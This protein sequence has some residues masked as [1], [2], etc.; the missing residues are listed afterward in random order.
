MIIKINEFIQNIINNITDKI[1]IYDVEY[2]YV[3]K[4]DHNPLMLTLQYYRNDSTDFDIII[5]RRDLAGEIKRISFPKD[6][7]VHHILYVPTFISIPYSSRHH[8][9]GTEED[10][11]K[12]YNDIKAIIMELII[13]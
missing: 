8:L 5:N 13:I 3:S 2:K 6:T 10:F 12:L 9:Q 7:W 11:E 4:Y 1:D